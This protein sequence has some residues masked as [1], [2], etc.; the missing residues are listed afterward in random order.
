MKLRLA[1][2]LKRKRL[3]AFWLCIVATVAIAPSCFAASAPSV[4]AAVLERGHVNCGVTPDQLGF[5][6]EAPDG[7]WTGF[8]VDF[9]RAVATAV[10][11]T[12]TAVKFIAVH[13]SRHF[14]ALQQGDVDIIA[15]S[16]P[17]TLSRD[18]EFDARV[19][20]TSYFDGQGFM[21]GRAQVVSSVYEL[22]GASVCVLSGTG[23]QRAVVDFFVPRGMRYKI[24]AADRWEDALKNYESGGCTVLTG[25][26][27]QLAQV[28]A[29]L[30]RPGD[31]NILP[32]TIAKRPLGPVVRTGDARWF[33]VV[34]WTLMALIEAEELGISTT[35]LDAMK[36]SQLRDVRRFLG[37][38]GDIGKSLGLQA[39][40]A[41]QVVRYVGNY[42]EMFDR[43]LGDG[44]TLKLRRGLNQLWTKGGLMVAAPLR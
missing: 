13:Q 42:A 18:T 19:V 7:A 6:T 26:A 32:E 38:E 23:A 24:I 28:R 34:R 5:S 30:L 17:L 14:K 40:W 25:D 33:G 36:Q 29:R 41:A 39:D 12:P 22:S 3:T 21:A 15:G 31:H 9:C 10:F 35:N 16:S 20:G 37:R 2:D 4:M 1:S 8:D 44:S 43:T 27:T 11:A